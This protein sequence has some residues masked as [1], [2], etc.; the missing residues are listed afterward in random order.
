MQVQH[1][2][3]EKYF[4]SE[5]ITTS[6][7]AHETCTTKLSYLMESFAIKIC[8]DKNEEQIYVAAKSQW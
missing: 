8:T 3:V 5:D 1:V 6:P 4:N 7:S 2:T